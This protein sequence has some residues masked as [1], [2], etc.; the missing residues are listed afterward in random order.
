MP[1]P[2]ISRRNALIALG[3]IAGAA[4]AFGLEPRWLDTTSHDVPAS[5]LP[6]GLEGFKIA[7]VT[8]AHL[9]ALGV[10]DIGEGRGTI[11]ASA[12]VGKTPDGQF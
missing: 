10:V 11:Y 4:A 1:P 2:I 9:G 12:A 8:D 3:G 5:G 7:Q 6:R